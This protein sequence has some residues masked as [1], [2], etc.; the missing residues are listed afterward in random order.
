MEKI[1][2]EGITASPEERFLLAKVRDK[3]EGGIRRNIPANSPFLTPAEQALCRLLFG[4]QDGIHFFGGYPE[5]ER[6]MVVYL[7]DYLEADSLYGDSSPVACLRA[8]FYAGDTLSHRDFLGALMGSGIARQT[9]GDICIQEGCCDF[10]TTEEIAPFLL[11]NL[12]YA[13]RTKLHLA[14][15]PLSEARIPEPEFREVRDTLAS[16]RLDSV[17]SAGFSMGRNLAVQH[18]RAER[19]AIDGLPC[20]KPDK[21]VTEGA[22]ISLR[23]CGKIKLEAVGA[24]TKKGRICVVI[25]RYL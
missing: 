1:K 9:V 25:R 17:I 4:N 8:T 20:D 3:V 22:K 10:F 21:L 7:P 18:I 6:K 23:G 13:G 2:L 15:I 24:Q 12:E 16:L 14:Q 19:A 11:Q 5:A